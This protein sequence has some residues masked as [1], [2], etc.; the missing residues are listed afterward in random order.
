MMC[1][2]N[3]TNGKDELTRMAARF[4]AETNAF[5]DQF[6][7][8]PNIRWPMKADGCA[9]L[10][11]RA[12][13]VAARANGGTVPDVAPPTALGAVPE[14]VTRIKRMQRSQTPEGSNVVVDT[15]G[16]P[17]VYIIFLVVPE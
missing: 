5:L 6:W 16:D 1:N 7:A 11:G 3:D 15:G 9:V 2:G 12:D 17:P 8:Q 10:G 14:L 4:I 13:D